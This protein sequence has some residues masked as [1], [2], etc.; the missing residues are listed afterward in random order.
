MNL[1]EKKATDDKYYDSLQITSDRVVLHSDLNNF[2]ASVETLY[3]PSLKNVPMAICGNE[4][5]RHGIILAKNDLAKRYG[6]KTGETVKSAREKCQEL[7]TCSSRYPEYVE[8]S[9]AVRGVYL[10][11]T[12]LVEP[13]GIDEAWLDISAYAGRGRGRLFEN[14]ETLADEIREKVFK[15]TGLKVSIG[16]SFNKTFSKLASDMKRKNFMAVISPDNYELIVGKIPARDMIYVGKQTN[17]L[18]KQNRLFTLSD[19][20]KHKRSYLGELFGKKG[21][22]VWDFARG[23]DF[24]PVSVYTVNEDTKS[25]SNSRTLP[26]DVT[27]VEE[28]E[29]VLFSLCESVIERIRERRMGCRTVR[30]YIRTCDLSITTRQSKLEKHTDSLFEVF[31]EVSRLFRENAKFSKSIRSLGVALEDLDT[32]AIFQ[33]NV[34]DRERDL[35]RA[36]IDMM[37]DKLKA[38]YGDKSIFRGSSLMKK[39]LSEFNKKHPAFNHNL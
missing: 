29:S 36:E 22:N 34:F 28:G 25:V 21:E 17:E 1:R 15:Q 19:V 5:E 35:K 30:I 27:T 6:I 4:K 38:V 33:M 26:Y 11:Y 12:P 37:L 7:V 9:R 18:L 13:F 20:A 32:M 16:V 8:L 14:A 10:Q 2:F 24:S 31:S 39:E 23:H 3:Q